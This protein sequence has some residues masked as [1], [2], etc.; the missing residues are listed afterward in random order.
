[1]SN[2]HKT[3]WFDELLSTQMKICRGSG[4]LVYTKN[5][6]KIQQYVL[7]MTVPNDNSKEVIKIKTTIEDK[8]ITGYKK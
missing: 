5:G 8:I 1:V 3:A 4:V 7:S 6:W 2:D